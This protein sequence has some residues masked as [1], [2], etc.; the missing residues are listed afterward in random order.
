MIVSDQ[1]RESDETEKFYRNIYN[2]FSFKHY[3]D[4]TLLYILYVT[5]FSELYDFYFLQLDSGM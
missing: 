5:I 1:F 3:Y 4:T 2:F